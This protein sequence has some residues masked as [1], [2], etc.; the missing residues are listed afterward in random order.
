MP[1]TSHDLTLLNRALYRYP[2][3]DAASELELG[4]RA[5]SGDRCA[6]ELLVMHNLRLVFHAARRL[7]WSGIDRAELIEEGALGLLRAARAWRQERGAR[8]ATYALKW[9]RAQMLQFALQNCRLVHVGHTRAG[10]RLFF[11]LE[12]ELRK[13][14]AEGFEPAPSL[15]AARLGVDVR[16]LEGLLSHL[17][18]GETRVDDLPL[19]TYATPEA[20]VAEHEAHAIL[21]RAMTDFERSLRDEREAAVWRSVVVADEPVS[22]QALGERFGI[23]KQRVGQ[24]A[25]R[26][27]VRFRQHL[28]P[29]AEGALA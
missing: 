5:Q 14:R 7:R 8:F 23:S 1:Q 18:D 27:K 2:C 29:L 25:E 26:L 13:L 11:R 24:I 28:P 21:K 9:I 15:L 16:E 22:L 4:R 3:L 17:L 12:R 6:I 19:A 10:R 20:V